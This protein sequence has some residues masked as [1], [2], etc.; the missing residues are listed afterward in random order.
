MCSLILWASGAGYSRWLHLL[1]CN[2]Q[3]DSKS[4]FKRCNWQTIRHSKRE[5]S[6][7]QHLSNLSLRKLVN[8]FYV[9]SLYSHAVYCKN[10]SDNRAWIRWRMVTI[11]SRHVA[12]GFR[13]KQLTKPNQTNQTSVLKLWNF[14]HWPLCL[15]RWSLQNF[16]K[17]GKFWFWCP[18]TH[19]MG[20]GMVFVFQF[21][22]PQMPRQHEWWS[23]LLFYKMD[24]WRCLL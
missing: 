7:V 5:T 3:P 21:S 17:M 11:S 9:L 20:R 10:E 6:K 18:Q 15:E 13:T 4:S 24:S 19:R 8:I 2:E 16:K 14:H 22:I 23:E 1:N 12:I